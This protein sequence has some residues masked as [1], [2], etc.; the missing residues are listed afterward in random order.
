MS[1]GPVLGLPTSRQDVGAVHSA[2]LGG[3][4]LAV[5]E[6]RAVACDDADEVLPVGRSADLCGHGQFCSLLDAGHPGGEPV[7]S[8]RI[9]R[10]GQFRND[11]PGRRVTGDDFSA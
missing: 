9:T 10:L 4:G 2:L 3:V 1:S 6:D 7:D 5:G 11:T 8:N